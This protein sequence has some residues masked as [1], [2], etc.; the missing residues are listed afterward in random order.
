MATAE[1]SITAA[2][3]Q[4][5]DPVCR[6]P[7]A[8]ILS[9][10]F[11]CSGMKA[12]IIVPIL[13]VITLVAFSCCIGTQNPPATTP[14]PGSETATASSTPVLAV[15]TSAPTDVVPDYNMVTVDVGEKDDLGNIPVIFQGGTGQIYVR[16]IDVTLYRADGETESFALGTTKGAEIRLNGTRQK[17]RVVIY[18]S[19]DTG[20]SYKIVDVTRDYRTRG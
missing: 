3:W 17:D 15:I 16:E 5:P 19:L 6:T 13:F 11:E 1:Y 9:F 14:A 4:I 2:I 8:S 18:V 10:R 20:K 7:S 12:R